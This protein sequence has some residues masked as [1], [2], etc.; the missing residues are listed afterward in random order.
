VQREV[1]VAEL[2]YVPHIE[3]F[4]RAL[5]INRERLS[6]RSKV[7]VDAKLLKL[8]LQTIV[9]CAPFSEEY[10]LQNYPDIAEAHA[11]GAVPDLRRHFVE[12]GYFEGRTGAPA[13]VDTGYYTRRYQDVGQAVAR[14]EL[15]SA[16]QHFR[17]SG[18]A[19]GRTPSAALEPVI[20]QWLSVLGD[21]TG[22][23]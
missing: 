16:A 13:D 18:Y 3:L 22:R 21:N 8:L 4:L 11:A 23:A 17:Q 9:E 20:G 1:Q 15:Q 6:S 19:E 2:P 12:H 5:R 14:G 7:A 10:Y